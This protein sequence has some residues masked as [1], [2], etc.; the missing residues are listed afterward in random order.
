MFSH[1]SSLRSNLFCSIYGVRPSATK[2]DFLP[3]NPSE[4]RLC[5]SMWEW[6][7]LFSLV[8][9]IFIGQIYFHWSNRFCGIY[10]ARPSAIKID[11]F[12]EKSPAYKGF[13][14]QCGSGY[15]LNS[16]SKVIFFCLQSQKLADVS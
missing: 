13:V 1:K 15:I 5:L 16:G 9:S 12:P 3:K 7:N 14:Y 2:I 11:F 10:G 8:K 4:K 6:P